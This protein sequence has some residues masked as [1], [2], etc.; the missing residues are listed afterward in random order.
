M[1]KT[2]APRPGPASPARPPSTVRRAT[3]P[4]RRAA[5]LAG[6]AAVLAGTA[7]VGAPGAAYSAPRVSAASATD[8]GDCPALPD[9]VEPARWRCEVHSAAPRLTLGKVTV[10]LAPITMT[11]AEGPMPDGSN[12]QVWGAMHSSPTAVP[13]GLTGTPG[14]DRAAVLGLAIQPEY[15][16]RSDFYTGQFSLRF[17]LLG[18]LVPHSCTIGADAP[19]DFQLK[20]SGPS[21]WVSQDPPVIEFSAY[22]D[23]FTA[24]AAEHCGPLT[25]ALNRRLGL[26]ATEGNLLSYDASYTFRTYDQ[27]ASRADDKRQ[28]GGNLSR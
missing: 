26:P 13:G 22:D 18:P 27:L 10:S 24:P 20:R 19:V 3:S 17:R 25:G 8:F 9:G 7:V 6:A 5:A 16:G 23:T 2:A 14:G 4:A 11:H 21:K 12:G 15:G 1:T 28:N